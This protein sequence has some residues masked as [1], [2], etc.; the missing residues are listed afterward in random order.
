[1]VF[2]LDLQLLNVV[3]LLLQAGFVIEIFFNDDVFAPLHLLVFLDFSFHS[4]DQFVVRFCLLF[5]SR[6]FLDLLLLLLYLM[7]FR[8]PVN[9]RHLEVIE[10]LLLRVFQLIELLLSNVKGLSE[11]GNFAS[12]VLNHGY[13]WD[14]TSDL[15]LCVL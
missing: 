7:P 14:V 12:L 11:L 3:L 8:D 4:C 15:H 1:M 10:D 9:N 2:P 6:Q 5:L 13:S